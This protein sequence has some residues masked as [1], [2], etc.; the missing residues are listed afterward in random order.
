[1]S[2]ETDRISNEGNLLLRYMKK[3]YKIMRLL[4][5]RNTKGFLYKGTANYDK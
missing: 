4:R 2:S 3:E 1:M 5:S